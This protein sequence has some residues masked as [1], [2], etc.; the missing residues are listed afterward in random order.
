MIVR[1]LIRMTTDYQVVENE[2]E[3]DV[4]NKSDVQEVFANL[5]QE[6]ITAS[7]VA[8]QKTLGQ[9]KAMKEQKKLSDMKN[10]L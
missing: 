3:V 8:L 5:Q 9:I 1:S 2:I 6:V 7:T 10:M 4:D